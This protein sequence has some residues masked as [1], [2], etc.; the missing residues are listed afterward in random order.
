MLFL[1]STN[2]DL[3]SF[4][5]INKFAKAVQQ[6]G[7]EVEFVVWDTSEHVGEF[8]YVSHCKLIY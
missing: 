6:L 1:C 2:D 4:D 7:C 3:A 8:L 5:T